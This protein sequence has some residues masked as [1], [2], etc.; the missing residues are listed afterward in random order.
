[1]RAT[2]RLSSPAWFAQPRI[3]SSISPAGTP[4]RSRT[5]ASTSAAR[6]SGRTGASPPPWRPKGSAPRRGSARRSCPVTLGRG[7]GHRGRLASREAA[8]DGQPVCT[9]VAA[10]VHVEPYGTLPYE[11]SLERDLRLVKAASFTSGLDRMLIAPMLVTIAA[12][13]RVEPG[14]GRRRGQRVPPALRRDPAL[15]GGALRSSRARPHDAPGADG[16]RGRRCAVVD[17]SQPRDPRG[18]T[19][20]GRGVR[21]RGHPGDRS[22]SSATR[23]RSIGASTSWPGS[24]P[25]RQARRR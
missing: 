21:G 6:S 5:S 7:R 24:W 3:T 13:L 11:M 20:V 12:E 22:C 1:M 10:P 2:S 16:R 23:S 19:R 18:R 17:R 4:V 8:E 9:A 14:A 15:L 25:P